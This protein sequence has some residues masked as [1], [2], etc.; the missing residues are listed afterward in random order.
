MAAVGCSP[1]ESVPDVPIAAPADGG[2]QPAGPPTGG[3][4]FARVGD[5]ELCYEEL[6]DAAGEPMLLVMGLGAQ[7]IHWDRAF[8]ELLGERGYRVIRFDNRDVGRSTHLP[9]AAPG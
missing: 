2:D 6:G 9:G 4:R 3:E 8:C 7:M 1:V 5:L